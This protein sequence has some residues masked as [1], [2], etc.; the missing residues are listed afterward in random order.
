MDVAVQLPPSTRTDPHQ[1]SSNGLSDY[2]EVDDSQ[3]GKTGV[4]LNIS[5]SVVGGGMMYLQS[6]A[7]SYRVLHS[8]WRV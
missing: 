8:Q 1:S 4:Q 7:Y 5:Q 3:S 6:A 2:E